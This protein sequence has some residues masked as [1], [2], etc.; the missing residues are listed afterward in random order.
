MIPKKKEM[1]FIYGK[2]P[3]QSDTSHN[4]CSNIHH[5]YWGEN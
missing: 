3:G 5:R 1:V 4:I 2:G